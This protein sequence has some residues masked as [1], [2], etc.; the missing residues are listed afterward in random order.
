VV[1]GALQQRVAEKGAEQT[2]VGVCAE[3][4]QPRLIELEGAGKLLEELV[5]AVEPLQEGHN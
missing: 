5:D 3:L 2:R 4:Y 1:V